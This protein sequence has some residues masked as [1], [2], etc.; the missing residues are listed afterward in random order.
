MRGE[1]CVAIATFLTF[2][3]VILLIFAHVGQINTSAVPRKLAMVQLNTTAYGIALAKATGVAV[4][5]LYLDNAS[6]PLNS[7]DGLRELYAWGLYGYCGYLFSNHTGGLCSNQTTANPFTP[8][9][10][11]VGD[12]PQIYLVNTVT[13]VPNAS[14]FKNSG[15]LAGLTRPGFWMLLIGTICAGVALFSGIIKHR[16]T[17]VLASFCSTVGSIFLLAGAS[18]WTAAIAKAQTINEGTV[19]TSTNP[20]FPLGMELTAGSGLYLFW[21]AFIF[22][23]LAAFPYT[24]STWAFI[25]YHRD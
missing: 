15:Y 23:A 4:P 5:G 16:I 1:T 3:S 13:L 8:M 7:G 6:I 17:F 24:I 19:N 22:L 2:V 9:N 14:A 11:I 21:A 18:I 25:R 12:V 20:K 10:A